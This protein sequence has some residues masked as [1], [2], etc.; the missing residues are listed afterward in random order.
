MPLSGFD[1]KDRSKLGIIDT[2]VNTNHSVLKNVKIASKSFVVGRYPE[3]QAHG[4]TVASIISGISNEYVGL[5]PGAP[6]YAASVFVEHP[7]E[8]LISTTTS[9]IKALHWLVLSGVKV[10]NMSLAGPPNDLLQTALERTYHNGVIV[11]AA[12]GNEGPAAKPL[13]PAGYETV[14][15]VTA[16]SKN[17]SVYRRSVRGAHVDLAAPGVNILHADFQGALA[18]SSGTS[19]AAP[20]VTAV[21]YKAKSTTNLENHTIVQQVYSSAIDLGPKGHDPVFGYGLVNTRNPL[22]QSKN[23]QAIHF[24]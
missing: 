3:P 23:R 18:V 19:L 12:V 6:L 24:N 1:F 14:V 4:T 10:I 20:F 8:G 13:Y 22:K 7:T 15:A 17:H 5:L 9:L 16:V 21:L 11:V 2:Q